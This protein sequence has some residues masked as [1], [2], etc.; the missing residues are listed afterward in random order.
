LEDGGLGT[1]SWDLVL[2][3][4]ATWVIIGTVLS[5][6]IRSS[7]KASYFLALF[8]YVIMFVL[9][10]RAVTL[11]GAWQGIVYFMKPQWSQ[12]LNPH[13]LR[14]S[15]RLVKNARRFETS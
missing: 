5:K 2:C 13:V 14:M 7:G 12:L 6:G 1:P 11:P 8:P 3:L 15:L 4:L 10:I 9:L